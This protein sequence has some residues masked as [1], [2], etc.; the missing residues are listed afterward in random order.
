VDNLIVCIA[1]GNNTW[2]VS[3]EGIRCSA[4]KVI[5]GDIVINKIDDQLDIIKAMGIPPTLPNAVE[6]AQAQLDRLKKNE[7]VLNKIKDLIDSE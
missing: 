6:L 4:C 7:R 2:L 5:K 3:I 1:C